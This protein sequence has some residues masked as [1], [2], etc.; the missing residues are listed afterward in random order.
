MQSRQPPPDG[1]VKKRSLI[2]VTTMSGLDPKRCT[3]VAI[4]PMF[5]HVIIPR[6]KSHTLLAFPGSSFRLSKVFSMMRPIF[7]NFF[8]IDNSTD[9]PST[10]DLRKTSYLAL[11]RAACWYNTHASLVCWRMGFSSTTTAL[12]AWA[13]LF[14][15][16][17]FNK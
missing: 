12:S 3:I 10:V 5:S 17:D 1:D 2:R 11:V 16:F 7:F 8:G 9:M 14:G 13:Y 4:S 15:N 6:T